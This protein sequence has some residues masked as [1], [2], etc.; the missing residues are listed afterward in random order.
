MRFTLTVAVVGVWCPLFCFGVPVSRNS[1]D[2]ISCHEEVSPGIVGAWQRSAHA[3]ITLKDALAKA[4]I[5]QPEITVKESYGDY[6]T[7]RT[8]M[9]CHKEQHADWMK[10]PHARAWAT[11][12]KERRQY[13]LDCWSCHV[14]G[15]GKEGGPEGPDEVGPLKNVQ[16][17]ACHGPGKAHVA[18]PTK[19]NIV[20]APSE[21]LCK[22]CHTEE[23][24]E[25]RFVHADYLPKVDHK[26]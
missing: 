5:P 17:E 20:L 19:E 6:V 2:C 9:G 8:C 10:T 16:C 25:G 18:A 26:D 11:L 24:T 23:Q 7:A 13:D 1:K 22:E 12:V 14:T 4:Q 21:A 15:A 3:R